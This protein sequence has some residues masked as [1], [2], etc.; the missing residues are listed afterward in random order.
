MRQPQPAKQEVLA[1]MGSAA[2]SVLRPVSQKTNQL[3][4]QPNDYDAILANYLGNS[5][6]YLGPNGMPM[7]ST[8]SAGG[9]G[10]D[11]WNGKLCTNNHSA[12][13]TY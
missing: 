11:T 10:N 13:K 7:I 6:Y 8:Y 2:L 4:Y 12:R 3:S 9:F 1:A 5:A